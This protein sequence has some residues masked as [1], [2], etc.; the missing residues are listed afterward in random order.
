M[1]HPSIHHPCSILGELGFGAQEQRRH[2]GEFVELDAV[3]MTSVQ[4]DE[5][6]Q[7]SHVLKGS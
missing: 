1:S 3:L 7:A 6:L 5:V 4:I 2:C